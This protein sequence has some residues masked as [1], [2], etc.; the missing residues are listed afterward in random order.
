MSP[1]AGGSAALGSGDGFASF[2]V[3][4]ASRAVARRIHTLGHGRSCVERKPDSKWPK[5]GVICLMQ[6]SRASEARARSI[7]IALARADAVRRRDQQTGLA[8]GVA[9]E[10]DAVEH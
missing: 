1:S 2:M 7:G 4:K 5:T 3:C 6:R 10:R 9:E 8:C